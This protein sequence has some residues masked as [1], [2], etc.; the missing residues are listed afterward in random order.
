M[1]IYLVSDYNALLNP[2]YPNCSTPEPSYPKYNGSYY[3]KNQA[4]ADD[5]LGCTAF[6]GDIVVSECSSEVTS[7]TLKDLKTIND[8]VLYVEHCNKLQNF[9]APVLE[10]IESAMSFLNLSSLTDIQLPLLRSVGGQFLR[11]SD[12][13]LLS[14]LAISLD[15]GFTAGILIENTGLSTIKL[16]PKSAN[17][18]KRDEGDDYFPGNAYPL[19]IVSNPNL[20]EILVTGYE[21]NDVNIS[22]NRPSHINLPSLVACQSLY[23]SSAASLYVPSLEQVRGD[24][25]IVNSLMT[26]LSLPVLKL[27]EKDMLIAKNTLLRYF[28]ASI[29]ARGSWPFADLSTQISEN[30]L[31]SKISLKDLVIAYG[32]TQIFNNPSLSSLEL[33]SLK[34]PEYMWISGNFS[35]YEKPAK[36]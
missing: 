14:T 30:P 19:T 25:S 28:W 1:R 26:N 13:P 24:L 8:G 35:R 9:S 3:I 6:W 10:S 17:T 22:N 18:R 31:L 21:F 33:W 32:R 5:L 7:I 4:D 29:Q 15:S 20:D 2:T 16:H 23:I 11:V 36:I 34:S 27:V 12:A